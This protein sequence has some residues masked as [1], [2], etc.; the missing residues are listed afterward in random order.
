MRLYPIFRHPYLKLAEEE[1]VT[2][3][4]PIFYFTG[5]QQCLFYASTKSA[6][7]CFQM[8][9]SNKQQKR[10]YYGKQLL[11]TVYNN[12]VFYAICKGLLSA[13]VLI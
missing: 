10:M 9:A 12:S 13:F 3:N 8:I 5:S 2:S 11:Y 1:V 4:H 6:F 7:K